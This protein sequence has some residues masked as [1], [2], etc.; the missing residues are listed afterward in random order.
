MPYILTEGRREVR[1][2]S[3][4]SSCVDELFMPAKKEK[5]EVFAYDCLP[6]AVGVIHH[7]CY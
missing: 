4:S 5:N 7:L 3:L 1:D 6:V 2:D